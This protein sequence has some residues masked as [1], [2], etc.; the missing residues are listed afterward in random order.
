MKKRNWTSKE[1]LRIVLKGLSGKI[2]ITKLCAKYR[3]A[4]TQY[5][6]WR[7]NLLKTRPSSL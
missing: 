7:D 3:I 4:N 1:K 6:L 2:E 5:C